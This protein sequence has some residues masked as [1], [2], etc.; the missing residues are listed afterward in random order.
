MSA[1]PNKKPSFAL[2]L[3][4]ILLL[5]AAVVFGGMW[6]VQAAFTPR[7]SDAKAA[8]ESASAPAEEPTAQ[9][10]PTVQEPEPQEQPVQEAPAEYQNR[11]LIFL[12]RKSQAPVPDM[13]WRMTPL[14]LPQARQR[15]LRL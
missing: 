4:L 6:V 11:A 13:K 7:M 15:F 9:T 10:E 2:G 12:F 14:F 8:A 5:L 3:I 1:A